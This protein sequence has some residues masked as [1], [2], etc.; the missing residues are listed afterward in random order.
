MNT[1]AIGLAIC[2]MG[3]KEVRE[4]PLNKGRYPPTQESIDTLCVMAAEYCDTYGI[5]VTPETVF[6]HA[7]VKQRWGTG[8]YKWDIT[9]LPG[10]EKQLSARKAG[11]IL[12]AQISHELSKIKG[13]AAKP[14]AI[15]EPYTAPDETPAKTSA[16]SAILAAIVRIFKN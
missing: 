12:R 1:D 3:G 16:L 14:V 5:E 4:T 10:H 7:E 6:I 13:A 8:V 15:D 11:D 2:A 9:V